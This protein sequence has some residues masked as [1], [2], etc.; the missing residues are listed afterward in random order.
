MTHSQIQWVE[1][2]D[3]I[4]ALEVSKAHLLELPIVD[5]CALECRSRLG[6]SRGPSGSV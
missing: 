3:Q 6:Y 5:S 4:F 2:Q 1:E